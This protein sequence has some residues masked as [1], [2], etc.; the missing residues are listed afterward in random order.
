MT[1]L[2]RDTTLVVTYRFVALL[3]RSCNGVPL[4]SQCSDRRI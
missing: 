3:P 4:E 1:E 2:L